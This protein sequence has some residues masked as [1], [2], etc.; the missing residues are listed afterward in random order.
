VS[1]VLLGVC[2]LAAPLFADASWQ[3]ATQ[4]AGEARLIF[5]GDIMPG[6]YVGS[7]MAAYG[8]DPPV[9]ELKGLLSG[10]DIAVGNLEGPIVPTGVFA[11]PR[12]YPNLLNLTGDVRFAGALQRAGF[13]LVSLA[14]NH[15]YDSRLEGL[16]ATVSALG[17]ASIEPVGMDGDGGQVAVVR[18]VRG[19][20]VAFLGYTTVL[21][22]PLSRVA[23]MPFV[24]YIN[25]NVAADRVRLSKEVARARQGAD[26]V[27]LVMHWGTEYKSQ[28]NAAQKQLAQAAAAAGADL[29]IGSHPHVVQGMETISANG[30]T[31][32]VAYSLGNALF[33]QMS[34]I[35]TRQGFA[36]ECTVDR[37][38]V[39]S[40]RLIP[41]EIRSSR[42]GY[43][44]H[45]ADDASGQSTLYRAA[46]SS[47]ASLL[48]KAVWDAQRPQPGIALAYR[49]SPDG[50]ASGQTSEEDLGMGVPTRVDL[51]DGK[52]TV[53]AKEASGG[54]KAVWSSEPGWKVTGYSVGDADADDRSELIYTLWKRA[55]VS[56]R[57][58]GGG[59]DVD[60]NGGSLLPHIYVNGWRDGKMRPVWH[61]SPRPAPVVGL[62]VVPVGKA[63]KPLLA[64]LE[65]ADPQKEKGP[66]N[67]R[68]WEWTGGFG[69]ELATQVPGT[70]SE[71]W[72]DGR[73][74]LAR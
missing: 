30:K 6:R 17:S 72:S 8:Y 15:S 46:W 22:L 53:S 7:S 38:G 23:G 49:R 60:I 41:L 2:L 70:W 59:L 34:K 48:W 73:V 4:Q 42:R 50:A 13:D 9:V 29:V 18:E 44:T 66:G 33:D 27:V 63:E 45:V 47:P 1:A 14:N 3:G 69:Y 10:A 61:G 12:P 35:E 65:S 28:P 32:L 56:N 51:R 25:P 37:N 36:L 62:A 43:A 24:S 26:I 19:L 21:N 16:R 39:R 68:L 20:R 71:M 74:L 52:L 67:L 64:T 55:L 40:A 11:V 54:Y 58:P 57:P 31:T 5:V